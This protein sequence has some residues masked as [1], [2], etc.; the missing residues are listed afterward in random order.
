MI[1]CSGRQ[2]RRSRSGSD[3]YREF[4]GGELF[5]R[6]GVVEHLVEVELRVERGFGVGGEDGGEAAAVERAGAMLLE[7][8]AMLGG[9]VA[10]VAGEAVLRE[11]LVELAA[12]RVAVD[13]GRGARIAAVIPLAEPLVGLGQVLAGLAVPPRA[14][15]LAGCK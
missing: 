3:I 12:E 9:G 1:V 14:A 15:R 7:S 6:E 10:L 8:C 5:R 11:L 4:V 13:L 2:S